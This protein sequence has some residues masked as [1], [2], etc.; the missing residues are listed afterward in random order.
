MGL[1]LPFA[2][3]YQVCEK[4]LNRLLGVQL[5]EPGTTLGKI[6]ESIMSY[7]SSFDYDSRDLKLCSLLLLVR[8]LDEIQKHD[9]KLLEALRRTFVIANRKGDYYGWRM[10][11]NTAASLIR[12]GV[13]FTK[14]ESPDFVLT[15]NQASI[16]CG[17]SHIPTESKSNRPLT[18][19]K[20]TVRQK[21]AKP[22]CNSATALF[23]DVTN[24]Y[25][26]A[27]LSDPSVF[28]KFELRRQLTVESMNYGNK[29]GSILLFSYSMNARREYRSNYMRVDLDATDQALAG[30]LDEHYPI[31]AFWSG[32]VTI[33]GRG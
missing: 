12:K 29:Y 24:L 8:H 20:R 5:S 18:K 17:S 10:E 30:F 27:I 25:A 7:H 28:D 19:L 11:I 16:E 2:Y 14:Q 4:E 9:I 21:S 15:E 31:G 3:R 1:V 6:A 32:P 22:Y 23:L 33:P 26:N 13:S